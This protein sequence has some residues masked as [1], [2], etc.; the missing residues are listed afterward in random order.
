VLDPF[1]ILAADALAVLR[2]LSLSKGGIAATGLRQ[3]S[4]GWRHAVFAEDEDGF[5]TV[6]SPAARG[7]F[8][9]PETDAPFLRF[10]GPKL[11]QLARALARHA[12]QRAR[13]GLAMALA[14][15]RRRR[16]SIASAQRS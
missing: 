1:A 14:S 7:K 5:G 8:E 15:I 4:S 2:A 16:R 11:H 13:V 12:Q 10:F 9:H 3:A 6:I